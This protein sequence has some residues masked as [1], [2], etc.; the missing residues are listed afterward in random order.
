V[1]T[2]RES[3]GAVS[4]PPRIPPIEQPDEAQREALAKTLPGRD[5]L[6]LNIFKTLAHRPKLLRR[7]NALAGYFP[8]HGSI[9]VREREIVILRTA[10]RAHSAYELAHHRRFA[11]EAGL[12]SEEIDAAIDSRSRHEWSPE[13]RA[14]LRLA[15]EL[16]DE[17]GV[18]DETWDAL[19][20]R[21]GD[22]GRLEL[23]VL[24]GLYRMLAGVLNAVR[25]EGDA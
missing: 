22:G 11:A 17:Q 6:P 19:A 21:W 12:L 4:Q 15:D 16:I 7:V 3:D 2:T 18:A 1:T 13:D 14:L 9:P 20:D 5:G 25:V 23:L 24:V 8:V 10:A